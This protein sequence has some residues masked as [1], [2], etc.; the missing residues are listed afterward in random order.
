MKTVKAS[1]QLN[2]KSTRAFLK[3]SC[4][5]HSCKDHKSFQSTDVP[6]S[7]SARQPSCFS[8]VKLRCGT[9]TM[10]FVVTEEWNLEL[11]AVMREQLHWAKLPKGYFLFFFFFFHF[12]RQN[13][14][15]YRS[16]RIFFPSNWKS[17]GITPAQQQPSYTKIL[18]ADCFLN[19]SLHP[20]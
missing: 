12:P 19:G 16:F 6:E 11:Q 13:S 8:R 18:P 10:W 4:P 2:S 9:V 17:S 15:S 20:K 3:S 14:C 5:V 7:Q 1:W